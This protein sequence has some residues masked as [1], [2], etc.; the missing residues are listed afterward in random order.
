MSIQNLVDPIPQIPNEGFIVHPP[1]PSPTPEE[2]AQETMRCDE[3]WK[4]LKVS[5]P[6]LR[7][8]T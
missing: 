8:R 7:K 3:A 2:Q 4:K 5:P 1:T 6:L